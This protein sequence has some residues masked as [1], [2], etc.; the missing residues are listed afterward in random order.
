MKK[1]IA[2]T[3]LILFNVSISV[4][5]DIITVYPCDSANYYQR[6]VSQVEDYI[7][8]FDD[9][10]NDKIFILTFKKQQNAKC[11]F[12][13]SY[14]YNQFELSDYCPN[15]YLLI[16]GNIVLVQNSPISAFKGDVSEINKEIEQILLDDTEGVIK[17]YHFRYREV[18]IDRKS[19]VVKEIEMGKDKINK[20]NNP[21]CNGKW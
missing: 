19:I 20:K 16:N 17:L 12:T 21:K 15:G 18:R 4:K 2:I 6:I 5:G 13:L 14:I 3:I 1:S 8:S 10:A 9:I 7:N 11:R